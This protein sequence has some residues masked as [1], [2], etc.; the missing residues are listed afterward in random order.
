MLRRLTKLFS[1]CLLISITLSFPVL[2]GEGQPR[3]LTGAPQITFF[4]KEETRWTEKREYPLP[5]IIGQGVKE[6]PQLGF[7]DLGEESIGPV[8]K[9][10]P[11]ATQPGCAYSSR[12]TRGMLIGDKAYYEKGRYHYFTGNYEDA[13]QAFEKIIQDYPNSP[14]RGAAHYWMGEAAF[15]QGKIEKALSS[16]QRVVEENPESEFYAYALYSCGWIQLKKEAYEEGHRFFHRVY[17]DKPLHPI[18]QS[19]LFWSGYCLYHLARYTESI[20]EMETLLQKYPEGIW[21]PE[22]EYLLGIDY[23]RLH[24]FGEAVSLFLHF[25]KRYE[26]HPLEE[27]VLYASA[28][29]QVSLGRYTEGRKTFEEILLTFPGTKLSDP[30]FFGILKT[31]LGKHEI[32]KAVNFHQRFLSHFLSSAWAEQT[33]FEIGQYY[34]EEKDYTNAAALFQQF[35]RTHPESDL[36]ERVYF[37]LGESRFNQKDYSRAIIAYHKV[38]EEKRKVGLENQVLSRLGYANFYVKNYD[39]AI[40]TWEKLLTDFPD[41]PQKNEILY[42]LAE[43]NLSQQDYP[44]AV[45]YVDR[46]KGD[47]MLYPKGLT[48]LGWHHF[49]RR[50]WREA[51]DYFLK[52]VEEFPQYQTAPSIFL[53][54]GE[55]Y[56]N[57]NDYQKAKIYLMRL[58]SLSGGRRR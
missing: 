15:H 48:S 28:W 42:W 47:P 54:V 9:M 56:L 37:M 3:G 16:F 35:L 1:F 13:I 52:V 21:R 33:F 24:R 18:A 53:M 43:V 41:D 22:A 29:S 32:E 10:S 20:L 8:K 38:L 45:G 55:C 49:Q 46:L 2:K 50:N 31:Y 39:E 7:F 57:Q 4:G 25:S 36:Q 6:E 58:I 34:F 14:R 51:N 27:S 11:S 44:R 26:Q 17:E 23:F 12:F 40:R 30:I 5:V 19:S